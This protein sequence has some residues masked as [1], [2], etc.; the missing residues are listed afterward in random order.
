MQRTHSC[1]ALRADHIDQTVTLQG[2]V[3][4]FRD[5]GGVVFIDLRDR[6][7]VTQITFDAEICGDEI[8][9][10]SERIRS[11]WVIGI[12]GTVKSR[13]DNANPRMDTGASKSTPPN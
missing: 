3:Q 13:G 1:G 7:G 4:N 8:R 9:D 11:E 10:Q 6:F 5:H 2:W 12:T